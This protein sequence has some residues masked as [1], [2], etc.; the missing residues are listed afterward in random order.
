VAALLRAQGASAAS[1]DELLRRTEG[2]AAGLRL[3]L[4]VGPRSAGSAAPHPRHVFDFLADEVLV[5]MSPPLRRFLLRCS[6]LP[7]LTPARCAHVSGLGDAASLFEQVERAGLFVTAL[8]EGGRT[9]RLHDLFRDFLE[10][11]LQRDHADELPALLRRAAD[12]EPDLV[13]AVGWLARAGDWE[14]AA[15]ELAHRGPPLVP[16]GGGPGIERLLG[17]FPAAELER[18]PDLEYLR[19]LCAFHAFDFERMAT[20][21]ERAVEGRARAGDAGAGTP[22]ERVWPR[23]FQHIAERNCGRQ[24]QAAEG[25]ARLQAERH[26]G[27][28]GALV[29]F[30]SAWEAYAE[31]R[32]LDVTA[33]MAELMDRLEGLHDTEIWQH[34]YFVSMFAGLPGMAPLFERFVRGAAVAT[35]DRASLLRSGVLHLRAASAFAAGRLSEAAEWLASAD[36]DLQWLGRPRSVLTENL[37]LHLVIDAARGDA[38]ACA[39]AAAQARADLRE[40]ALANQRAHGGSLL[41]AE[42]CAC[43]TLGDA[44]GVRRLQQEIERARNPFE[45]PSA[46]MERAM[47]AGMR[48]LLD[49]RPD[50]AERLLAP[51]PGPVESLLYCRGGH[52][53]ML[54]AEAL[55]RQGR[56]DAAARTLGPWLGEVRD[57]APVGGVLMAGAPVMEALAAASWG[58]RLTPDAISRLRDLAGLAA[59][60][61]PTATAAAAPLPAGLTDREVEVLALVASGQSNKLIARALD[62]SPFTVKRHVANI[63]NKTGTGSR[64]EVATWWAAQRAAG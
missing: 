51:R 30:F 22:E 20:S 52:A 3:M 8:D 56:L 24:T 4:Q 7:E 46:P 5:G 13:R 2:W 47:A 6:V 39:A 45:W 32:P 25:F 53:L 9:L 26:P 62:L 43:W 61:A 1:A 27:A 23:V 14:R 34:L 59:G 10:D 29:S 60:G 19:G 44:A 21:M 40:S 57:G 55:R 41:L 50:E 15:I 37:M 11:R 64:T 12:H 49:G 36:E 38:A 54:Y 17:L 35:G 63:L 31:H 58:A 42:A 28:A 16:L 48:A 18:H 33:N